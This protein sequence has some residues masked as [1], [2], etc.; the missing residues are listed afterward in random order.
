M[1]P[2]ASGYE[3]RKRTTGDNVIGLW[4]PSFT[5]VENLLYLFGGGGMVT[6]N[7]TTFNVDTCR[8]STVKDVQGIPPSKRY[9]HSALLY[10]NTIIIF[11]MTSPVPSG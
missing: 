1:E 3:I 5:R 7:L 2:P 10:K 11:G 8:W 4:R 6:N 9:G